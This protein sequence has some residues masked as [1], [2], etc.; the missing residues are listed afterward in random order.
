MS[1]FILDPERQNKAREYD[2]IRRRL[3]VLDFLIGGSYALAWLFFGW[4]IDLRDF[5][6]N[7]KI[8]PWTLVAGFG[9]IFASLY[10]ILSL[11]LSYYSGYILHVR[12]GMSN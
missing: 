10:L 4:S 7:G 5:L 8:N 2:R 6:L 12:Y 1:E 11:P 3:V 9:L